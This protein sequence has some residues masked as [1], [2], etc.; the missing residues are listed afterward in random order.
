MTRA[1]LLAGLLLLTLSPA[2]AQQRAAAAFDAADQ[3]HDGVISREEFLASRADQFARRDRNRDGFLDAADAGNRMAARPRLADGIDR[4]QQRLDTNGDG[5]I[6]KE[7]FVN[8][9]ADS[10]ERADTDGN[11]TVD[12]KERQAMRATIRDRVTRPVTQ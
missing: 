4:Q 12:A 3:N 9:G 6:S 10:F 2:M 7:E 11:G 5:K 1:P 8:G